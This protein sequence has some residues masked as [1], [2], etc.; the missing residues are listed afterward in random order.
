MTVFVIIFKSY[1]RCCLLSFLEFS[2]LVL[3]EFHNHLYLL[4]WK[5]NEVLSNFLFTA[6][7]KS[8]FASL[9]STVSS[10]IN[11]CAILQVAPPSPITVAPSFCLCINYNIKNTEAGLH[12]IINSS[13]LSWQ[14]KEPPLTNPTISYRMMS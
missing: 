11:Y 6:L 12:Y 1:W 14:E 4:P 8:M 2:F 9:C 13:K 10:A 7:L 3:P 5:C